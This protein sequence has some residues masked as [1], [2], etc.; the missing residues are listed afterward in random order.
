M[1]VLLG[2]HDR[3]DPVRLPTEGERPHRGVPRA[4]PDAASGLLV[5]R[6]AVDRFLQDLAL[7]LPPKEGTSPEWQFDDVR[8]EQAEHVE[9]DVNGQRYDDD[10]C[11]VIE[12][13]Y[14]NAIQSQLVDGVHRPV[15]VVVGEQSVVQDGRQGVVDDDERGNDVEVQETDLKPVDPEV[16]ER[17]G[18]IRQV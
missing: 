15:V 3:H 5:P 1:F 14:C 13:A 8:P 16:D 2:L 10:E 18:E 9:D 7:V 6:G 11:K 4:A 17:V 12:D